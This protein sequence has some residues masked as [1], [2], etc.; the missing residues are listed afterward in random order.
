M[1][2]LEYNTQR[3][4]LRIKE[5]GRNIQQLVQHLKTVKDLEKRD[6]IAERVVN[7]MA[8]TN[9]QHKNNPEF[10]QKLW[11]HLYQIADYDINLSA[12]ITVKNPET[13]K[14]ALPELTYPQ[15]NPKYKHYGKGIELMIQ[16]ALKLEGEKKEAYTKLI[17]AYMKSAYRNWA[18][19]NVN[20][21][22][23]Y[24]DLEMMS[25]NQLTVD[26]TQRIYSSPSGN[27]NN[28]NNKGGK[29]NNNRR[30]FKKRSK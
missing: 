26:R 27:N 23:I 14:K 29:K 17:L 15:T 1:E 21:D 24:A 11:N 13:E 3:E 2:Q 10:I 28:R 16:E 7:M 22:N 25:N 8:Q 20:D 19:D 18:K 9:P 4:P 5:Y 30:N 12:E 6:K